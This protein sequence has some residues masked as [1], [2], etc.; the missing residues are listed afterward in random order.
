MRLFVGALATLAVATL[1]GAAPA[2]DP[3]LAH[4]KLAAAQDAER[5][6]DTDAAHGHAG[7]AKT[8]WTNAVADY[9]QAIAAGDD[10]TVNY[11]LAVVE[12]KLGH[13]ADAYKH[14]QIVAKADG[15]KP[16][17][18]KKVQAKLDDI[19]AK[20]GTVKLTVSPDG[21]QVS[22]AGTVVGTSPLADPLVLAPGNYTVTL[23]A[24]GYQPKD[25][26]LKV[27]AG[28]E[29]EHKIVLDAIPI[30]TTT[31]IQEPPP[32]PRPHETSYVPLF[33][34]GGVT[35]GFAVAATLTG[36]AAIHQHDVYVDPTTGATDRTNA[37]STG[38][39]EA[40][41]TDACIVGAIA[42]AAVTAGWYYFTAANAPE[43][44]SKVG[45]APWVQPDASG[46][47]VAGSF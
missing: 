26:E 17:L 1:A 4:Q 44:P 24:P 35:L 11:A 40:H 15:V 22:V 19:T 12:D 25:A 47:V 16:D 21:A 5:R 8:Q 34:G 14:L 29:S 23:S 30:A 45:V 3:K 38:R 20:V 2:K 28:S 36:L 31:R 18:M 37:Q 27:Q 13:H 33:I 42:A 43:S 41:V 9:Q 7:D 6:G 32:T 39:L 46:L 10:V